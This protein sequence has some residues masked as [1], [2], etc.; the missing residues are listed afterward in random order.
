MKNICLIG[1]NNKMNNDVFYNNYTPSGFCGFF[2]FLY[3][4]K[5]CTP[6][7]F[8]GFFLVCVS[9]TIT[10]LRDCEEFK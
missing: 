6:S 2:L 10:S 8:W 4:Y 3:V 5:N 7:G 1:W 9:I